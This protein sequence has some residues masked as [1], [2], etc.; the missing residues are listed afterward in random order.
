MEMW[1]FL[2]N[3]IGAT[4]GKIVGITLNTQSTR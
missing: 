1:D 2:V 4:A 3:H